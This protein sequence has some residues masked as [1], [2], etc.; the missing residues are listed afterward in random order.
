[1]V[2]AEPFGALNGQPVELYT[3]T[4]GQARV[5]ILSYGGIVQSIEVPDR[6]GRTANVALGFASLAEYVAGNTRRTLVSGADLH[7][8]RGE[9]IAIVGDVAPP[10]YHS[11]AFPDLYGHNWFELSRFVSPGAR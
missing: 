10:L 7:V 11:A 2:D 8:D 5:R 4:N 6:D 3:L 9:T 1:M